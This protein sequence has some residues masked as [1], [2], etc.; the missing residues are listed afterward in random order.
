MSQH[1]WG[2]YEFFA[3][4][5]LARLA[6]GKRWKCL[7][8]NEI[9]E[10]KAHVY[11]LNFGQSP[12]LLVGDV[13]DLKLNHLPS[14]STLAW[15][16]F[17]CQDLSLAGNGRGLGGERSGTFVPFW[18]LMDGAMKSGR[19]VPLVVVENVGGA[20]TSN[21]GRDL[22][23]ILESMVETGYRV[24]PVVVDAVRFL[25]QSRPRLFILAVKSDIPLPSGIATD[26][27]SHLWHSK[28]LCVAYKAM[29]ESV[30]RAWLWWKLPIPPPMTVALTN[31][32][33][34]NPATVPWHT[35]EETARLLSMMSPVNIAK[36][37]K[38]Q[39]YNRRIAGTVYKR[40][41]AD[42]TGNKVQRAEVRFDQISGCLRT[43][44]GGSSRQTILV[45][46][47]KSVRSRLLSP[48][49]AARLMG[50][51]DSYKLP[52]NYNEAYHVMG[53]GLAVPA[54]A[55]LEK[56][57]LRPLARAAETRALGLPDSNSEDQSRFARV[58]SFA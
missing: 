41:R 18:S 49:E 28:R 47:C 32:L 29:P 23:T 19:G 3:G 20:I 30:R 2:F 43:P 34:G 33:E 13:W 5:G 10:K 58:F 37:R 8:A 25:P 38:A 22:R 15:A 39:A 50:V 31:V 36:V 26:Y 53:D 7:V 44:V 11:R 12:E 16:S 52:K 42:Q 21:Q 54:V 6:L 17:P 48:R 1:S 4:G 46:D 14:G 40:M 51:P 56:H 24:G 55:W 45:V 35:K 9:C 57:L 27:P